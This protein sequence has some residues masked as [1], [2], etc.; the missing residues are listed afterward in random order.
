M[1]L[2]L[3]VRAHSSRPSGRDEVPPGPEV[4]P[5]ETA[6]PLPVD[7]GLMDRTLALD[8]SYHLPHRTGSRSSCE[9]DPASDGLLRF[10]FPSTRQS[11]RTPLQEASSI[12]QK[13]LSALGNERRHLHSQ[14]A[15][16]R[17]SYLSIGNLPFVCVVAHQSGVS[18]M[19]D[20]RN[21]QTSTA[22]PGR[23]RGPLLE[24]RRVNTH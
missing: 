21:C 9:R 17:L 15:W 23:A 24:V 8:K 5:H 3:D 13:R 12:P 11:C 10:G 19:D 18:S 22:T 1:F 2:L 6:L 20:R 7:P 16:L 14:S 4:L